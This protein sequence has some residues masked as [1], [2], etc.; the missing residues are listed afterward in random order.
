RRL[1]GALR[2][3]AAT[4][5]SY[6]LSDD[7]RAYRH[8]NPPTTTAQRSKPRLAGMLTIMASSEK[9]VYA[10]TTPAATDA[11][12]PS[13]PPPASQMGDPGPDAIAM[14]K[15][16]TVSPKTTLSRLA[17]PI[18]IWRTATAPSKAYRRADP[19]ACT[20]RST[21]RLSAT[22]STACSAAAIATLAAVPA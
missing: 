3:S 4:L 2:Q 20:Q 21:M 6:E 11:V 9:P 1:D 17:I 12:P 19:L 13:T 18:S 5:K 15:T 22:P 10:C 7:D 16:D 14:P 8:R